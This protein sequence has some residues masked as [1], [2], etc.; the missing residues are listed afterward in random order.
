MGE[1]LCLRTF[2]SWGS[3]EEYAAA[4]RA[5]HENLR[6]REPWRPLGQLGR[7]SCLWSGP[8]VHTSNP[9]R[10]GAFALVQKVICPGVEDGPC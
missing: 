2:L 7:W 8:A 4:L 1:W 5:Q 3:L 10:K 6:G 9:T